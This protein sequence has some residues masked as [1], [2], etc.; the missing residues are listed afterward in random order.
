MKASLNPRVNQFSISIVTERHW[1]C[2]KSVVHIRN[3]KI[4]KNFELQKT[5]FLEEGKVD[6]YGRVGERHLFH[7]ST[8]E[9]NNIIVKENFAV[10]VSVDSE[11]RKKSMLFGL[12][13]YLSPLPELRMM[14]GERLLL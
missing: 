3:N 10:N 6:G 9:N 2:I 13:I 11:E 14:Y 8:M 1:E 4:F 5:R 7:G 12:G